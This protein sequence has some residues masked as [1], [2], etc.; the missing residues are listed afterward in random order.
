MFP[1]DFCCHFVVYFCNVSI[2]NTAAKTDATTTDDAAD[3]TTKKDEDLECYQCIADGIE[4]VPPCD[5]VFF[6]S[7]DK[8]E[9]K[10]LEFPCPKELPDFCIKKEIIHFTSD[11][12]LTWR[13][14]TAN[15]DESG[16]LLRIGCIRTYDNDSVT[17]MCFCKKSKCNQSERSHSN[18]LMITLCLGT[19]AVIIWNGVG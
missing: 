8:D 7:L 17:E 10:E 3:N 13:G 15:K 4:L 9:L 18:L 11:L 5:S 12:K 16:N 2:L 6:T 1:K 19:A 14:C